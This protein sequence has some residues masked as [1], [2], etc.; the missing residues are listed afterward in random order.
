MDKIL[1]YFTYLSSIKWEQL[2]VRS[3]NDCYPSYIDLTIRGA[4]RGC[5]T[6]VKQ[7]TSMSSNR[8]PACLQT[9]HQH[10][11]KQNTS[12][13]SNRTPACLQTEHQ[14]VFKQNTSM[15]SN[16]YFNTNYLIFLNVM[17]SDKVSK[18]MSPSSKYQW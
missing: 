9:E 8:T 6:L 10:V 18:C 13:S 12:M 17:Q 5:P 1:I 16:V 14:H 4:L 7:N 2:I 11:F 3:I 15:S